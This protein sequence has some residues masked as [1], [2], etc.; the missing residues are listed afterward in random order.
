MPNR[1]PALDLI[2]SS[3][4]GPVSEADNSDIQHSASTNTV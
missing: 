3:V 1:L 2:N 4:S